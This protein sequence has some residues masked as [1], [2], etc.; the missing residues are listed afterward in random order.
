MSTETVI[1]VAIGVALMIVAAAYGFGST[2]VDIGDNAIG[3]FSDT[4]KSGEEGSPD[5]TLTSSKLSAKTKFS[6]KLYVEA[7]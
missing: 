4:A 5:F 1:I 2:A 3:N 6:L 7:T